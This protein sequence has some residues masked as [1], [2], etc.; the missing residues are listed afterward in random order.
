MDVFLGP[1][2]VEPEQ[3]TLELAAY[4]SKYSFAETISSA[5]FLWNVICERIARIGKWESA[6]D[7]R[8][9]ITS[10]SDAVSESMFADYDLD[11][12]GP[13]ALA[14][15][16]E[17]ETRARLG[18]AGYTVTTVHTACR[19][20]S[21]PFPIIVACVEIPGSPQLYYPLE[22]TPMYAGVPTKIDGELPDG[23][24]LRLGGVYGQVS[25]LIRS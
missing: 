7:K 1:R 12:D 6:R 18:A 17:A 4:A 3:L 21:L 24:K 25:K 5:G 20:P 23:R 13:Y 14:G 11:K 15:H 2:E 16:C 19:N 8:F 9:H 10:W 22:F